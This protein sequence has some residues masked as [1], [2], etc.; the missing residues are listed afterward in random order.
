MSRFKVGDAVVL[1]VDLPDEGLKKG[2]LGAVVLEFDQPTIAYET[3]FC[4]SEG[5]T[6][7]QLALRP[8]QIV[9]YN[10]WPRPG[11]GTKS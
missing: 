6:V 9:H 5:R 10:D 1:Q 7:A 8:D 2:Q 4:D 3:E 11:A